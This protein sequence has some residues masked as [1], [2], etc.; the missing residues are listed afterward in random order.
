MQAAILN[1]KYAAASQEPQ[2]VPSHYSLFRIIVAVTVL[3]IKPSDQAQ[4]QKCLVCDATLG[5][6]SLSLLRNGPSTVFARKLSLDGRV[7]LA[8]IAVHAHP[9]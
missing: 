8:V 1:V 9:V 3:V 5:A 7:A 4:I 2:I 6:L